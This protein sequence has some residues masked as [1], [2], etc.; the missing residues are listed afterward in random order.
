VARESFA[1][2]FAQ[3]EICPESLPSPESDAQHKAGTHPDTQPVHLLLGSGV[4]HMA[5]TCMG[6]ASGDGDALIPVPQ[7][8]LADAQRNAPLLGGGDAE[9][10]GEGTESPGCSVLLGPDLPRPS[11]FPHTMA[12]VAVAIAFSPGGQKDQ[13]CL[14]PALSLT[15]PLLHCIPHPN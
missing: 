7:G 13:S 10:C 9:E 12:T 3:G 15:P 14:P 4:S 8:A 2:P 5:L 1:D 11:L 6:R